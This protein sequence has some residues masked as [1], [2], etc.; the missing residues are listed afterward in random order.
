MIQSHP[1]GVL[2]GNTGVVVY[3]QTTYDTDIFAEKA[4]ALV[5]TIAADDV[6]HHDIGVQRIDPVVVHIG[7]CEPP[8]SNTLAGPGTMKIDRVVVINDPILPIDP[9]HIRDEAILD[10]NPGVKGLDPH[11]RAPPMAA[12]ENHLRV[13]A[14]RGPS[15]PDLAAVVGNITV[16]ERDAR[17]K[18]AQHAPVSG[19]PAARRVP[20]TVD[21]G[22]GEAR[23]LRF[24]KQN[25]TPDRRRISRRE[26]DRLRRRAQA[27]DSPLHD[28]V[29]AR[30]ALWSGITINEDQS[31]GSDIQNMAGRHRNIIGNAHDA[32][33]VTDR[34]Y[35]DARDI[36]RRRC[37]GETCDS[38]AHALAAGHRGEGKIPGVRPGACDLSD[39]FEIK[40]DIGTGAVTLFDLHRDGVR[41]G[42]E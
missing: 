29:L 12:P 13:D 36:R 2:G 38:F 18:D 25:L 8:Q 10:Q 11:H 34:S 3:K 33:P 14:A 26:S 24:L 7:D 30:R 5:S 9:Q 17:T 32:R 16:L 21:V 31:S 23:T 20:S 39:Q 6:L 40:T 27:V 22:E 4:G 42:H 41:A 35:Q 1:R 15:L 37:Q 28:D 19:M